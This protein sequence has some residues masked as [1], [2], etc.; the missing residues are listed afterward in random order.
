MSELD[1][2]RL[3][4]FLDEEERFANAIG[5]ND[6]R[7]ALAQRMLALIGDARAKLRPSADGTANYVPVKAIIEDLAALRAEAEEQARR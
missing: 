6:P 5:P 7:R 1:L 3:R 4:A 2:N